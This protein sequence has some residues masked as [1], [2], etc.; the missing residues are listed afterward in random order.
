MT[1]RSKNCGPLDPQPG[2]AYVH[3]TAQIRP[4]WC[5]TGCN[6]LSATTVN[7]GYDQRNLEVIKTKLF[8]LSGA[9]KQI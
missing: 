9:N 6:L 7:Q 1:I 8:D 5:R 4:S 3:S 2:Y